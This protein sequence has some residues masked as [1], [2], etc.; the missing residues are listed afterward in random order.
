MANTKRTPEPGFDKTMDLNETIIKKPKVT[1]YLRVTSDSMTGAGIYPDDLLVVERGDVARD[2]DIIVA[3]CD[4]ELCV[5][6]L[7]I[8]EGAMWLTSDNDEYLSFRVADF[9]EF[10][11]WGRVTYSIHAA[12]HRNGNGGRRSL[13]PT[14]DEWPDIIGDSE[15]VN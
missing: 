1:F 4:G 3:R 15:E 11:V 10:E 5:K 7:E 12:A 9:D 14:S 2:G 8:K 13:A 6:R